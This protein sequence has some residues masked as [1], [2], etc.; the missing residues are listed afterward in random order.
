M[1]SGG[2]RGKYKNIDITDP[3][4]KR[5]LL[6]FSTSQ[7]FDSKYYLGYGLSSIK[8]FLSNKN[9]TT[10]TCITFPY[11]DNNK[12]RHAYNHDIRPAFES[13]GL[14]TVNISKNDSLKDKHKKLQNAQAIYVCGGN[15]YNLMK[16]LLESNMMKPLRE[17]VLSGT[18]YIG[19]SAGTNIACPTIKTSNDLPVVWPHTSKSL[20]L[21]PCLI[22]AINPT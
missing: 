3:K 8:S 2:K 21:I 20:N 5:N 19:A 1:L 4:A 15:T 18:P 17:K 10:V 14:T 6:L 13:I 12:E 22:F 11:I 9:V 7:M 16:V